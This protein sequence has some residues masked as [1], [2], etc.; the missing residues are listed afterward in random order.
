M[1]VLLYS[2]VARMCNILPLLLVPIVD[3][4]SCVS[5]DP[6][7]TQTIMPVVALQL[8]IAVDASVAL[9][10]VG[11]L[12]KSGIDTEHSK[13]MQLPLLIQHFINPFLFFA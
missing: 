13:Y 12:I 2:S 6:L 4:F 8:K 1:F 7:T 5:G 11:V 3:V 9:T 10:D